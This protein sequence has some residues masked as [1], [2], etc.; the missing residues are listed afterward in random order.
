LFIILNKIIK[1]LITILIFNSIIFAQ[2]VDRTEFT[3]NN[4]FSDAS[5]LNMVAL[6]Q[7]AIYSDNQLQLDVNNLIRNYNLA[8]YFGIKITKINKEYNFDSTQVDL[9]INIE[10]G[11]QTLIG[12]LIFEGNKLLNDIQVSDMFNTKP[13]EILDQGTLNSDISDLLNYYE[14][15]GFPFASISVENIEIYKSSGYPKLR[16]MVTIN[17]NEM[18][19]INRIVTEGNTATNE[20]VITREINLGKNKSVTRE[21]LIEIKNRLENLGYFESVE[22]PKILKYKNETVLY[23]KVKEG[24]TNT[25]DGILGYVPPAA[26]E[27]TGYITGIA[28]VSLKNLFGT[29]RKLEARYEKEVK[30][31][32]ELELKYLEPWFLGF[33]VNINLGFLQRV[34]DTIYV[35]RTFNLKTDVA[36]TQRFSASA[37][38]FGEQV[39]PTTTNKLLIVFNSR[40]LSTGIELK[41]D[42]RDYI[43]NP[44]K[45]I[46][47]RTS[48]TVGQKKI[49]NTFD[50]P[51]LNLRGDFTVQKASF[52][53]E[54]YSSFFKRQSALLS[55]HGFEVRSPLFESSDFFRF[56]GTRSVRGYREGQFLG[57]RVVWNNN[58]LRYSLTRRSYAVALFDM[59]YYWRP[60]DELALTPKQEGFIFGYGLGIRIETGLGMFGV[61]YALGRGDSILEGKVHFGIVNDF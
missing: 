56:G 38:F 35:K 37:L 58:E 21:N 39:I 10:E 13:G 44:F 7:G 42:S 45:G 52:E 36:I 50:Y 26:N 57:S 9:Y 48:Y 18:V 16:I 31:T 8:G 43:Y 47:L 46:L 60:A 15:K 61:S 55:F 5:L 4:Y 22:S 32:Q 25:F 29:G 12:E 51:T 27:S 40:L 30:T 33:P 23:I 1:I 3:G 19:K 53:L 6:K 54:L 11:N 2:K 17:E 20:D 24:N 59:G 28:N 14:S 49:Y 41:Y 34:E